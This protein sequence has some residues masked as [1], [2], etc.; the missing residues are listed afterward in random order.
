MAECGESVEVGRQDVQTI[1]ETLTKLP[2]EQL[3][4]EVEML[5]ARERQV[6]AHLVASLIE[7][8]NRG[9]YRGLG[10]SSMFAYCTKR[11]HLSEDATFNRLE[12]ARAARRIPALLGAIADGSLTLTVARLLAP[13]LTERNYA[14]LLEQARHKSKREA[15]ELIAALRPAPDVPTTIRKLAAARNAA[16]VAW[17]SPSDRPID[18]AAEATSRV[19]TSVV[20]NPRPTTRLAAPVPCG[21]RAMV[22]P[23]APERFKLQ[24]TISRDTHDKLRR[25]QDLLGRSV[26]SGDPSVIFDHALTLLLADLEKKKLARTDRPRA[27]RAVNTTSRYV[28]AA[29]KREVWARDAGRCAFVGPAGRCAETR[30]LEFHHVVPFADDGPTVASNLQLRC[31]THNMYEAELYFAPLYTREQPPPYRPFRNGFTD[32]TGFV[33]ASP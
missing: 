7:I 4:L 33:P 19:A 24:F 31:R 15:E 8:E 12:V 3:I 6:S 16:T 26:P 10:F 1:A 20:A 13:L 11:L 21:Q 17:A 9:L 18:C 22:T 27:P 32:G 28:P 29:V 25:V 23:L 5:A 14:S 2:D 30:F